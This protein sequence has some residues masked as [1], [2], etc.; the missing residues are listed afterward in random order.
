MDAAV[1]DVRAGCTRR[2]TDFVTPKCVA[3]VN[4]DADDVSTS[5]RGHVERLQ[6]LVSERGCSV[7]GRG[8]RGKNVQPTWCNHTDAKRDMTRINEVNDHQQK[9]GREH[10]CATLFSG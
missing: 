7:R 5:D 9:A 10:T 3:R 2:Y 8:C 6:R 4:A 1:H